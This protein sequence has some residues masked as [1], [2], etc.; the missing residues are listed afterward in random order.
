M[1]CLN[2]MQV[3]VNAPDANSFPLFMRVPYSEC[4]LGEGDIL[5]IP[6]RWW[7]F[8]RATAPSVSVNYWW[9]A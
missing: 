9:T 5:Y 7:H 1:S 8:V 4:T 3:D 2:A 6:R